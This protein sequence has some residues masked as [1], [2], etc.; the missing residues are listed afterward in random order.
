[1]VFR[2]FL[3]FLVVNVGQVQY[4]RP[5]ENFL[6]GNNSRINKDTEKNQVLSEGYRSL[7]YCHQKWCSYHLS[8]RNYQRF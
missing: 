2:N 6:N 7:E 3:K 8:F 1:M 4:L 5:N